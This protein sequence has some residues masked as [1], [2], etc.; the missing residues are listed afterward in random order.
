MKKV[1]TDLNNK[2]SL[3]KEYTIVRKLLPQKAGLVLPDASQIKDER[4][5]TIEAVC[6][7]PDPDEPESLICNA[8][9]ELLLSQS[10]KAN[11]LEEEEN[12]FV[13]KVSD[14][15]G[16]VYRSERLL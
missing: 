15:I 1:S 7:V 16:V 3:R 5:F 4:N 12:A 10:V 14:I 9:D 13:I 6:S 2:Y 11:P 8:G